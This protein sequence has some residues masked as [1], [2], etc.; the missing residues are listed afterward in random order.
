MSATT[1]ATQST[2][3]ERPGLHDGVIAEFMV[4]APVKPGQAQALRETLQRIDNPDRDE[5]RRAAGREIGTLH[6]ARWV[7]FDNDTRFLFASEFDGSWDTY[8]DDFATTAI[9]DVFS[10]VFQYAEGFPG[11]KDP[12]IK[13][14]FVSHQV[15]AASFVTAYPDLTVRQIWKIQ[16]VN[17]A[18]QTVLDTPEFQEAL[19]SPANA[20]LVAMPAFQQLLDEAA[21]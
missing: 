14:W 10:E 16:R 12:N 5:S 17:E 4:M 13:D 11:I 1:D 20:A 21:S 19:K 8:I 7:I 9:S 18:F 15:P 2:Q 3:P 6:T